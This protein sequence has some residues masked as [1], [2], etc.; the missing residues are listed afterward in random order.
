MTNSIINK[1]N[2]NE[3]NFINGR[4]GQFRAIVK[5][6]AGFFTVVDDLGI[7]SNWPSG[8]RWKRGIDAFRSFKKGA[9]QTIEFQAEGTNSWLTVFARKGNKIILMD[10]QLFEDMTVG[11]INQDWSNTNLYSQTNYRLCNAK[12][13]ADKAF[14]NNVIAG[15]DFSNELELLENL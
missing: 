1:E 13:W 7:Q 2:I 4:K 12:T 8:A 15:V 10:T 3:S 9:L 11:D 6:Q 14:V 5:V